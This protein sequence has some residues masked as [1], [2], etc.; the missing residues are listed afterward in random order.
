M[1]K[2]I[3]EYEIVYGSDSETLIRKVNSKISEGFRPYG[4]LQVSFGFYQAMV[5][6]AS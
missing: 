4:S 2:K 1:D 6:Y 3:V 5:K